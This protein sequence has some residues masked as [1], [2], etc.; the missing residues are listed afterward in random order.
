MIV[1]AR[2]PIKTQVH[3]HD[4]ARVYTNLHPV[5]V[6]VH[7]QDTYVRDADVGLLETIDIIMA[8]IAMAHTRVG[9]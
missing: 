1:L 6:C 2:M 7:M 5:R 9:R 8:Y 4:C 3:M